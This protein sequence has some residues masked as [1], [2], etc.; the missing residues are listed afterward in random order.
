MCAK[1]HLAHN[2]FVLKYEIFNI[3]VLQQQ[4]SFF[5]VAFSSHIS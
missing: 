1:L 4:W 3:L 2:E 5:V